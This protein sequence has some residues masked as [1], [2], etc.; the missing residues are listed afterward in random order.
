MIRDQDFVRCLFIPAA[1]GELLIP[2]SAIA[3]IVRMTELGAAG[4]GT[5][6]W[7][8][9]VLDWRGQRVPVAR[10]EDEPPDSTGRPHIV[11][12]FMPGADRRL[13]YAGVECPGLPLLERVTPKALE[14]ETGE[15]SAAPRFTAVPFKHGGKP[16]WI[17]DLE[18]LEHALLG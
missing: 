9:G 6:P 14:P 3:E 16:A 12:C 17:L 1:A 18:A 8:L 13:P 15:R 7:L 2:G 10:M 11:V 5:P 4:P